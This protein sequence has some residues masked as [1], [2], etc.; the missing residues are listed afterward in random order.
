LSGKA[1]TAIQT[2]GKT[3]EK[4]RDCSGKA[5]DGKNAL[6]N[7]RRFQIKRRQI[8]ETPRRGAASGDA[9]QLTSLKIFFENQSGKIISSCPQRCFHSVSRTS[10]IVALIF[11]FM[12][13]SG[14][15][16]G[17]ACSGWQVGNGGKRSSA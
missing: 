15:T 11:D 3:S 6:G 5:R 12:K 1:N 7:P 8:K 13:R 10:A 2:K 17:L 4:A 16:C 14:M 9:V